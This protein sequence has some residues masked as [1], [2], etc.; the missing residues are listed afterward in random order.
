MST[1]APSADRFADAPGGALRLAAAVA[2]VVPGIVIQSASSWNGE[3]PVGRTNTIQTRRWAR[4]ERSG[5]S[6]VR[7]RFLP[8]PSGTSLLSKEP[9]CRCS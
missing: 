6:Q 5:G 4:A 3:S 1:L 8:Y 2:V 9:P 7:T